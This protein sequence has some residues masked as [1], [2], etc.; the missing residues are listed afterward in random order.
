MRRAPRP[1]SVRGRPRLTPIPGILA[2]MSIL[3]ADLLVLDQVTSFMSNDFAIRDANGAIIADIR[4]EGSTLARM[5]IGSRKLTVHDTDGTVLLR[6]DDVMSLGRDRFDLLDANGNRFAEIVKQF[7]VFRKK[8]TIELAGNQQLE[9]TGN[10]WEREFQVQLDGHE[11]ARV[12]R[13]WPGL[14]AG[15][16]GHNRYV[17]QL[18]PGLPPA[19]RAAVIGAAI[20]IDL[21]RAKEQRSAASSSSS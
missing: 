12:T 17:L 11:V 9:L 21:V 10:V 7:T 3:D 8:F 13:T 1:S 14:A 2:G 18:A 19:V 5:V 6:L 4:T 16:L 15:I 20:A